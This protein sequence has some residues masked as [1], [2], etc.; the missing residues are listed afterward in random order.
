MYA[1]SDEHVPIVNYVYGIGGRDTT[2]KDIAGVFS[3]LQ[4]I[5]KTGE[6]GNPYRYFGLRK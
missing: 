5:V 4:E 2:T 3:D 1:K 6:V